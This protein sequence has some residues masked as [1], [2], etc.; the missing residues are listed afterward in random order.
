[1]FCS[2]TFLALPGCK[3]VQRADILTNTST[4]LQERKYLHAY[5]CL[6]VLSW[7]FSFVLGNQL[8][9]DYNNTLAACDAT[10]S[11]S[12]P[13]GIRFRV[14]EPPRMALSGTMNPLWSQIK[15]KTSLS[16]LLNSNLSIMD[17]P[18]ICRCYAPPYHHYEIT[19]RS[20]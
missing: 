10:L 7:A 4:C 11:S 6:G 8:G 20:N 12:T 14:S 13:H 15:L 18:V 19:S 2:S 3:Q 16:C 5:F 17:F 9:G 1:M